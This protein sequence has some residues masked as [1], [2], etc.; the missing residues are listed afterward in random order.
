VFDHV[1]IRVSDRPASRRFYELALGELG[2]ELT[3]SDDDFD[4]W[5]DFSI[6]QATAERPVTAGLHVAFVAESAGAVN[7]WWRALTERG[8]RD[9]GAPGPRVQYH[10]RYYGAFV[11]DPDGNSVEAVYHGNRRTGD[12]R[13]DHLWIRVRDLGASRGFYETI[14]PFAGYRVAGEQEDRV[15]FAAADRSFSIVSDSPPTEQVHVAFSATDNATVDAF[16]QAA[17][18]AAYTD[19]GVPGERPEYH[20][21]YYGAFVLDPDGNNVELVCHNRSSGTPPS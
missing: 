10:G 21:G 14:A 15:Q 12:N 20:A 2:F 5:W 9:D 11:R 18:R 3:H 17:V 7:A 16:H 1:T 4:E 6:A 13:I 19:N 8:H